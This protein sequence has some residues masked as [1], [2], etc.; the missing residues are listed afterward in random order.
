MLVLARFGGSVSV[1]LQPAPLN[2]SSALDERFN[3]P[4]FRVPQEQLTAQGR[5]HELILCRGVKFTSHDLGAMLESFQKA[6]SAKNIPYLNSH[7][8]T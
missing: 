3:L 4:F 1:A 2:V 5:G 7:V 8:P 6:L